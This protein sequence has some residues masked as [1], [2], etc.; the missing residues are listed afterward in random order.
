MK[1]FIKN[2]A[3]TAAAS[4]FASIAFAAVS[5][6]EAKQLGGPVLTIFGA[7][8][9][10]NKD[11]S[12]PTFPG[13]G[14]ERVKTPASFDPNEPLHVPNAFPDEKPL[15]SITAQNMDKYADKMSDAQK[16]LLKT[17]PGYH[18]DIYPTHRT[19]LYPKSMLDNTLKN[20]TACKGSEGELALVGCYAGVMFPIPK[21]GSQ[22]VWNHI[23]PYVGYAWSIDSKSFYVTPDGKPVLQGELAIHQEFPIYQEKTP[24]VLDADDV[25]YRLRYDTLG[26]AR[27]VGEKVVFSYPMDPIKGARIYQYIPGQ[28]RVKLAPDLAYDTP[29]PQSGGVSTMDEN[30]IFFGAQDR[31]D[32][33]MLGKKEIFMLYNSYNT[34]DYKKCPEE[35]FFRKGFINPDCLRWE[36]H[37]AWV[38]EAKLKPGNRHIYPRRVMYFD[39]DTWAVGVGDNYDSS[40]KLYRGDFVGHYQNYA[41]GGSQLDNVFFPTYTADFQT[42][43]YYVS[44]FTAY[45]GGGIKSEQ[46]KPQTYYSPEALSGQGIR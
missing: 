13:E 5:P 12:I 25:Y 27:K 46:P 26:P 4:A 24:R 1:L 30:R 14:G 7:E 31:Y 18:M 19:A 33:K 39:E 10:G 28:R 35:V 16:A 6:E 42:G 34:Y 17:Y 32:M 11:G 22:V 9:A 29:T 38:V 23:T 45:P 20:A 3:C 41:P 44:V 36:L 15:F 40:G 21:T 43:A 8:R 2:V 37:R